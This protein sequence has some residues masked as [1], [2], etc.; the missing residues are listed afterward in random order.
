MRDEWIM[1]R[2]R[3]KSDISVTGHDD[4][5]ILPTILPQCT[6]SHRHGFFF[7]VV[8]ALYCL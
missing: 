8:G 7:K 5:Q 1:D 3:L 6:S 2:S 4:F